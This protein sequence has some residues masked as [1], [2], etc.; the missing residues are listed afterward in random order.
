VI[1]VISGFHREVDENCDP[2]GYYAASC[3]NFL[4]TFQKNLSVPSS[5]TLKM[6]PI[7]FHEMYVIDYHNF[8]R[9]VPEEHSSQGLSLL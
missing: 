8:L 9:N 2:L 7:G 6:G 3:A 1:S 5:C 4:P